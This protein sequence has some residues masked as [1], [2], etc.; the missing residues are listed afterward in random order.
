MFV[1]V[2]FTSFFS[3]YA[4]QDDLNPHPANL[5]SFSQQSTTRTN[6]SYTTSTLGRAEQ[7]TDSVFFVE[8]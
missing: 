4:Q 7:A 5:R 6:W 1:T 2:A 3:V 8:S